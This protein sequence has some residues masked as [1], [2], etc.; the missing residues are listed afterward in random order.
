MERKINILTIFIF[1]CMISLPWIFAHRDKEGRI[2]SMENRRL[3]GYP[4]MRTDDGKIN[5]DYITQYENWLKDNLRGRTV[6]VEADAALQYRFFRRIVKE[7]TMRGK[8]GWLF[9]K[10]DE[11]IREYQ[12]LNLMSEEALARY[13][14]SM[15]GIADYLEE[16]GIAFYYF[17]CYS[18]EEIYPDRYL[19]GICRIGT[20]SR[21]DQIVNTLQKNT[22]V[23]QILVKEPLITHADDLLYFQY[24][25]SL[26]WNERGSYLGYQI[27]MNDIHKDFE[28]VPV[29]EEKDFEITEE[30]RT[31][32]LYGFEYPFPEI[33]PV[34]R[35][36]E[37]LAREITSET[38]ER[39][40]FLHYKEHTHAYI[41][42][43]CN[44]DMKILIL[45]DSFIRMFLKDDIAESFRET[46]SI[47]WLN[48]P[49]LD[50][51]VEEFEPDIV[52]IESAQSAL[53]DTVELIGEADFTRN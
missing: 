3:A 21:A 11:M 36:R 27:M 35:V 25:D 33:C 2:S 16:R 8:N 20:L 42:E 38:K 43:R 22:D 41:N 6:I 18:K 30:E 10:D 40:D 14:E 17:Q 49:I 37:P 39:W 1:M 47:D 48:I 31:I 28:E 9:V 29:L 34:Y 32:D 51:V 44:N 19:D 23:E 53:K 4:A 5:R 26:H 52:V 15:Q 45:G 7:D 12:R 24:V 50:E 13:A 46:L